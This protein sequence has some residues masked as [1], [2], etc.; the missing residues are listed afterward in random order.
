MNQV[1][2]STELDARPVQLCELLLVIRPEDKA[3]VSL[4]LEGELYDGFV[5]QHAI[6]RGCEGGLAY[7]ESQPSS[8]WLKW[9]SRS[10]LM[11]FLPKIVIWAVLEKTQANTIVEKV[12]AAIR[13]SGVPTQCAGGFAVIAEL[14]T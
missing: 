6:G 14:E 5:C 3:A 8:R 13:L 9:S 4:V 10:Y 1:N 2:H 12:G 7:G 11:A